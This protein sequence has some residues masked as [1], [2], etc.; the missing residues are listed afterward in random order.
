MTSVFTL[1]KHEYRSAIR[2]KVL[3]ALLATFIIVTS[4]SILVAA[5]SFKTKVADYNA[6]KT[7]AQVAGAAYIAAPQQ[8]PLQLLRGAIEYVEIIGAVIAIALGYVSVARERSNNTMQLVLSRP[9]ATTQ[10]VFG[11]LLGALLIFASLVSVT[12]LVAI[13]AIGVISGTWLTGTE[14]AK[15]GIAYGMSI[16]YMLLFY[17]LGT[18]LTLRSRVATNGLIVGLAI[19][20]LIVMILPQIGDTMDPD[21]QV[22]GGLFHALQVEKP[23]EKAIIAHFKTYESI[24]NGIEVSSIEKHYERFNFAILGIKDEFNQKPITEIVKAKRVELLT[25]SGAM[26]VMIGGLVF[27]MQRKYIIR[28]GE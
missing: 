26:V 22:P 17:C 9:V 13:V 14:I 6:Y 3:L 21:N 25:L 19:W 20:L 8:F 5:F 1:A 27:S 18:I 10:L 15:L 28:K 4:V 11:R 7:A 12:G 23:Q 16:I 2:S 24:R